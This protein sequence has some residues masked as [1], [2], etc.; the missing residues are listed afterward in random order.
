MGASLV[1][2]THGD[3]APQWTYLTGGPIPRSPVIGPDGL[4]R[5][6]STD[7]FLHIV[8]S[9]GSR[10]CDPA[11][12]GAPLGWATPL[13]DEQNRTWIA[14]ADGGLTFVEADGKPSGK[15]VYRTRRR[16]DCTGVIL[17]DLLY[18]GSEDHFVHAIPLTAQR[19]ENRW[20]GAS[21]GRTGCAISAPLAVSRKQELL[22]VSQD[23]HLHAFG[24]DGTQSW[25]FPLPGQVLGSA[26]VTGDDTIILG[27]SQTPRNQSARGLLLAIDGQ[28]RRIRWQ[29][30]ADEPIEGTPVIGDDGVVY[31]G[32]NAGVVYAVNRQGQLLWRAN[33]G[34]P[35]RSAGTILSPGL[36]AFGAED[37]SLVALKCSSQDLDDQ[38]WPQLLG[39]RSISR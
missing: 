32:D 21:L 20:Q 19:G 18:I 39:P 35:V 17:G 15:P 8:K 28:T 25:S 37:G 27:V 29:F 13:V 1:M 38:G 26:L 12:V 6:H 34:A 11:A 2:F 10:A 4:V 3:A 36:V 23:D 22:V 14:L 31:C 16:F 7:G 5:V 33:V 30:A 24:R 9:D